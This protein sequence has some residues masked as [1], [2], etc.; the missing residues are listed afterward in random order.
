MGKTEIISFI[1]S[2]AV[3]FALFA[4]GV[5]FFIY[6]Y[7]LKKMEH[8][9]DKLQ[10][11]EQHQRELLQTQ[12]ESQRQVMH[13]IGREIHDSVGQKLTLAS[14]YARQQPIGADR[15]ES[16]GQMIDESLQ[17]LRQLSKSLA[18]PEIVQADL[19]QLLEKEAARINVSG[20]CFLEIKYNARPAWTEAQKHILF[21]LLQEFIQNSLRYAQCRRI[22]ITF[23]T[24][25]NRVRIT[26]QDDGKGFDLAT[27]DRGLG[28]RSMQRRADELG[29][30]FN[31]TSQPGA[32]TILT[33]ELANN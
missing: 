6:Q 15:L 29:A 23:L 13:H 3:A 11:R 5:A 25:G 2:Y 30:S 16:I 32:G 26:A 1:I 18:D 24:D 14:I 27:V 20:S 12:L 28:L 7:R 17:E 8:E 21:R 22:T 4:G 19:F 9:K 33:L 10:L 31:M